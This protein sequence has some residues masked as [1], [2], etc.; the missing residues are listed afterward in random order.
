MATG[1][2]HARTDL[3][4]EPIGN[5]VLQMGGRKVGRPLDRQGL[6]ACAQHGALFPT[7]V[8]ARSAG[9]EP[10]P[11]ACMHVL[12]TAPSSPQ[13]WTLVPPEE[14]RYLRPTLSKDGRAYVQ[15]KLPTE[16]PEETLGHVRRWVVESQA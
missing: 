12:S 13:V 9:G 5:L 16:R 10:L 1:H 3:H 7:G 6:H 8:D 11:S 14:S 2:S 15:S 4:C